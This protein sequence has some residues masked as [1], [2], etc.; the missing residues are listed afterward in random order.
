VETIHSAFQIGRNAD[1][2]V[3]YAPPSRLRRY[4]LIMLDEASQVDDEVCTR[5]F[6]A[7]RE[8]PQRPFFVISADFQQLNPIGASKVVRELCKTVHTV[9]LVTV[10][11]SKDD[12]LLDFSNLVRMTQPSRQRVEDFFH[13]RVFRCALL[14]AVKFGLD[15]QERSHMIFT[16]L[17]VTNKGA[18]KINDAALVINGIT[19]E[20]LAV[21]M[22]GDHKVSRNPVYVRPG[23]LIRL[24]RNLDKDRG[25]VNGAIG[26]VETVLCQ[27]SNNTVFTVRLP[28]KTL[29]L[30][31][32]ID[33]EGRICLPC[34][35]GYATTV[36]RA[37]GASLDV[38]CIFFDHSYPPER[39]YGYVAVSRFRTRR[40][41]YHFGR[42]RRTD[43]LPVGAQ[44]ADQAIKRSPE[45][46]GSEDD[47]G[48]DYD[49]ENEEEHMCYDEEECSDSEPMF[50]D[51]GVA[52]GRESDEE[53]M[54][55]FDYG[56]DQDCGDLLES[57]PDADDV[58]DDF[59]D[60]GTEEEQ[61]DQVLFDPSSIDGPDDM[62]GLF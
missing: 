35:Y 48:P 9:D 36:R 50:Y 28:N 10:H 40:G 4:D 27:D 45:S 26:S 33:A 8:L 39:G 53:P 46:R 29:L 38:G 58:L 55:E 19:P 20:H 47:D 60:D 51:Y 43:W 16:W 49:S 34:V 13:G 7:I 54:I 37:Q 18:S 2:A 14:A 44:T 1:K 30:V 41:V 61:G 56:L 17:C 5:L 3:K 11:R 57:S 24:T 22:P 42:V 25:F 23:I 59:F 62:E 31:H 21:A 6:I 32:P 12:A 15:L 52:G